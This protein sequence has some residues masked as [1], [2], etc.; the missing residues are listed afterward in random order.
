MIFIGTAITANSATAITSA[1]GSLGI[2]HTANVPPNTYIRQT[3]LSTAEAI[4]SAASNDAPNV[5][6]FFTLN[7]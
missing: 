1:F 5:T 4:S 3:D 7:T 2:N 6:V